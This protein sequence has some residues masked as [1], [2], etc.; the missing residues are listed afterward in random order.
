MFI[1]LSKESMQ[2][3]QQFSP[4]MSTTLP[5]IPAR[6]RSTALTA[7]VAASLFLNRQLRLRNNAREFSNF[8]FL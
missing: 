6:K 8:N 5:E 7:K 4:K 3:K 2:S 1:W